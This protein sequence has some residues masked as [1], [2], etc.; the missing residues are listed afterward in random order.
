MIAVKT[1]ILFVFAISI[2]KAFAPDEAY[3]EIEVIV[4]KAKKI[5]DLKKIKTDGTDPLGKFQA[6]LVFYRYGNMTTNISYT[7]KSVQLLTELA[8]TE[9]NV[10]TYTYLGVAYATL[11]QFDPNPLKKIEAG[12]QAKT[13]F[14]LAVKRFPEHYLPRFYRA[15]IYL[16]MPD[17]AGGDEK[18]GLADMKFVLEK[19]PASDAREDFKGF[20]YFIYAMY[21]GE[22][23]S[24]FTAALKYLDMAKPFIADPEW[25]KSFDKKLKEYQ[26]KMK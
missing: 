13:M 10:Y 16:F 15:M 24:D 4:F 14:E 20:V 8:K 7:K 26:G 2:G 18:T 21:W 6:A 5:D 11:A 9:K 25:Q 1:A 12:N 22:K 3:K 23:K 17:F 19:L